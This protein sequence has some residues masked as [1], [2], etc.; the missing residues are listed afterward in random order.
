MSN[1]RLISLCVILLFA[2]ADTLAEEKPS[3]VIAETLLLYQRDN[4]GWPKNFKWDDRVDDHKKE[5]LLS[6][7]RRNDATIDNSATHNEIR[8]LAKAYV[9]LKDERYQQAALKGITF[10]LQAQYDNGGWPQ[11]Y[12]GAEGYHRYITF[13][14]NAMIAITTSSSISVKPFLLMALS[15]FQNM[16]YTLEWE[17]MQDNSFTNRGR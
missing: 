3:R 15:P 17:A 6:Q 12:P 13:N 2:A 10:L 16:D 8:Y 9:R 14:D 4:G 5:E 7:K 11:Y 1:T